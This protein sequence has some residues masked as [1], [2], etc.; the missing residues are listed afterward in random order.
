[1]SEFAG[2]HSVLCSY[3]AR[4]HAHG[5]NCHSTCPTCGGEPYYEVPR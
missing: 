3:Y 2:I 1:M 5:I 4:P